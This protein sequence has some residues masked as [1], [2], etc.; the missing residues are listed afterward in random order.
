MNKK[1]F[2]LC[3][4]FVYVFYSL[5]VFSAQD[6][7]TQAEKIKQY[8]TDKTGTLTSEQING[9]IS[10]LQQFDKET[11]NQI[12]VYM[13]SSLDGDVLESVSLRIA[14]E[15][16]IGKKDRNN[17]VLFFIAK[18]DRKMRI[19][20]GYGLE[21]ALPDALC[22]QI[23][24]N[25]V[26]PSFREN[27]YYEGILKGVDA[28]IKATKGEYTADKE[29]HSEESPVYT[30]VKCC[31]GMPLFLVIIF[32]FIFF[33]IFITFIRNIINPTRGIYSGSK[34]SG[35]GWKSGGWFGG[36]GFS[37]GSGSFGGGGGFSGGGGSFGGGGAS[38]SW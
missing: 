28:I 31:F 12:V 5:I 2:I 29:K 9:L 26:R 38:G 24:R 7:S 18:N 25:E 6:K 20:V 32:G 19:E 8:I 10:K 21:G 37:G 34:R 27:K 36:G 22:D 14:E 11:T 30:P 4:L 33:S 15:N 17:G 35:S 13:I 16:K 1:I 3:F 23:L